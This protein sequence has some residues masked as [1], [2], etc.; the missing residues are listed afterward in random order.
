[1]AK[2]KTGI[3]VVLLTVT[4]I[5]LSILGITFLA[6]INIIQDG[7]IG[8]VRRFGSITE[9]ISPG[10]WNIR[11]SW[12]HS[13]DIYDVRTREADL[14]FNAY[15]VD[16]QNVRGQVSIQY[17][18]NPG[19]VQLI[20]REFGTLEDL[21]SMLESAFLHEVQNVFALK[22][23]MELVE[24]RAGLSAEIWDRLR[25]LQQSFHIQITNVALEGMEFSQAFRDAVDQRIVADQR[26]RQAELDAQ[27]DLVNAQRDLDVTRLQ[28]QEIVVMAEA[29][30]ESIRIRLD[31][32]DDLVPEIRDIMLRQLAIESWD[33]A[34]PR[35]VVNSGDD[36]EFSLI[37]DSLVYE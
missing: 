37:L 12:W 3:T 24:H 23:A 7:T 14:R 2:A 25:P 17:R 10:G 16:A 27:R 6:S 20:A 26:L 21:E 36:R 32:W 11:W 22:P 34:L 28:G 29:D 4:V 35:V 31:A 19:S 33:G 5:A 9:T 1:M 15:S 13:V 18:L 30:A 8:V